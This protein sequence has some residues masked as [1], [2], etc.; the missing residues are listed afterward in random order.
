M[1]DD[2]TPDSFFFDCA[3]CGGPGGQTVSLTHGEFA[4]I[5]HALMLLASL[6]E[7]LNEASPGMVASDDV[8]VIDG[9][10]ARLP[11]TSIACLPGEKVT[12]MFC[13]VAEAYDGQADPGRAQRWLD[14]GVPPD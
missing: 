12:R 3:E 9:L 11:Y 5:K 2:D 14:S 10:A 4:M 8:A 7:S 6:A 13:V 1:I